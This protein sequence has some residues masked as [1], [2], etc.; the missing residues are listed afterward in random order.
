MSLEPGNEQVREHMRW[1]LGA[2]L[3][4]VSFFALGMSFVDSSAVLP[5]LMHRLG[6]STVL[7]GGFAAARSLALSGVQIV[8]AHFTHNRDKQKPWLAFVATV[9]RLPLLALPFILLHANENDAARKFA[10]WSVIALL[11][12]WALGDGLGYV[13]WVEIVA[14]AFSARVRGRFFATS[15][16]VSGIGS[17]FIGLVIVQWVLHTS[18]FPYPANYALLAGA[19]AIMFQISLCGVLLIKEPHIEKLA[20]PAIVPTFTEYLAKLPV[21]LRA[22]RVFVKLSL[23]QLLLGFGAAASPF[24]V[25]YATSKFHTDDHWAGVYQAVQALGIIS[26][27]PVWTWIS[28][29]KSEAAAI[30]ALGLTIVFTPIAAIIAGSLNPWAFCVVFFMMG[31]SLGWCLWI[32]TNHY[33]LSHIEESKRSVYVA[34][35]NLLFTPAAFFPWLGGVIVSGQIQLSSIKANLLFALTAVVTSMGYWLSRSLRQL[36]RPSSKL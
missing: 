4:D 1:N 3:L 8:V 13:P 10:L 25:I 34:L 2:L 26:L 19:A 21:L 36:D 18:K 33:L 17:V 30:R 32:V 27:S 35:M 11:T 31:G 29:R 12:F 23:I 6:A 15:Q 24:Y 5:L 14:R 16:V 7:I 28:E 9:T 22:D 20:K